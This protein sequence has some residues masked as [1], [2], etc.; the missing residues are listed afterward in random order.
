MNKSMYFRIFA[1][2][3]V[4]V[5]MVLAPATGQNLHAEDWSENAVHPKLVSCASAISSCGCTITKP[6]T[7]T[8]TAVLDATQGLNAN[9]DCLDVKAPNVN[10]FLN[11]F[12]ITGN[13]AGTGLHL[14]SSANN[15]MVQGIKGKKSAS[16]TQDPT[17]SG[18]SIG[19]EVDSANGLIVDFKAI[20]NTH[21]G[22]FLD[23]ARNNNLNDFQANKNGVYGVW[24][25]A[26]SG[27]QINCSDAAKNGNTGIYVGC[28]PN[29]PTGTACKG[30]GPSTKNK[31]YDNSTGNNTFAGIAIDL[32]QTKNAV[33]QAY[34]TGN[35]T[36]DLIDENSNCDSNLWFAGTNF[37]TSNNSSCIQ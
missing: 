12:D 26:S 23:K 11:G 28:S 35:G 18:W 20:G 9:G 2:L 30:T 33:I 34:S 36:D 25:E 37:G 21:V 10:L 15:A 13:S 24:L 7:Y 32:G 27:N 5:A 29:G 8:V 6:G 16:T 31:I 17:L 4:S 1:A 19:L 22:V 3:L 14:L